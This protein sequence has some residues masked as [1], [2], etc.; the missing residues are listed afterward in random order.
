[1]SLSGASPYVFDVVAATSK[2]FSADPGPRGQ[3][4]AAEARILWLDVGLMGSRFWPSGALAATSE[5]E[6][7]RFNGSGR[8]GARDR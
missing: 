4:V 7:E 6:G 5:A 8:P 3:R 2:A 1:M